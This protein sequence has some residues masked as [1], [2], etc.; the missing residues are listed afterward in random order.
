VDAHGMPV[1]VFVTS[2]TVHD[3]KKAIALIDGISAEYLLA[4]RAYDSKAIIE[5]AVLQGM[6]IV[7]PSRKNAKVKR[8]IDKYIYKARSL[9]ENTILTL[10]QWRGI[11]TRYAKHTASFVAAVQIRCIILWAKVLV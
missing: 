4:D 1:R 2:G 3:S 7:I 10:K 11:A 8:N 6:E 9:V 5:K